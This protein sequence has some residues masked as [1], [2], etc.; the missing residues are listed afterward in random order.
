[1]GWAGADRRGSGA[2]GAAQRSANFSLRVL[3]QAG[4]GQ[5]VREVKATK[6]LHASPRKAG[7]HSQ[8][9]SLPN[10]TPPLRMAGNSHQH[11][12]RKEIETYS[13]YNRIWRRFGCPRL[14]SSSARPNCALILVLASYPGADFACFNRRAKQ[15]SELRRWSHGS[16]PAPPFWAVVPW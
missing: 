6:M 3:G 12:R 16:T 2:C 13:A 14:L 4:T 7:T 15:Q 5:A 11:S 9:R 8:N 10:P 1:M